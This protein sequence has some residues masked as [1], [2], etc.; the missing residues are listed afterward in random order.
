MDN[1][2]GIDV[3][4]SPPV[5]P[6]LGVAPAPLTPGAPASGP[7]HDPY[8][9]EGTPAVG[10]P[11]IVAPGAAVRTNHYPVTLV[12]DAGAQPVSPGDNL[13]LDQ[14]RPVA[15]GLVRLAGAVQDAA[16]FT[17]SLD[18]GVSAY[19]LNGGTNLATGAWFEAQVTVAP[20]DQLVLSVS[21]QTTVQGFRAVYV[22]D[23]L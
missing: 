17:V 12:R 21:A 9:G 6:G 3:E 11:G 19:A 20:G 16:T 7:I 18:G 14:F 1:V 8:L 13:L 22:P 23:V 10:A 2:L 15:P 4:V 5:A